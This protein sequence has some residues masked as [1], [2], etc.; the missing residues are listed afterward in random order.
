MCIF[1]ERLYNSISVM[2]SRFA[3]KEFFSYIFEGILQ[4]L[5]LHYLLA[6]AFQDSYMPHTTN[7]DIH[8]MTPEKNTIYFTF[9]NRTFS[10]F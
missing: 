6:Y 3:C 5:M 1:L 9:T 10:F 7:T 8:K 4:Q 2:V